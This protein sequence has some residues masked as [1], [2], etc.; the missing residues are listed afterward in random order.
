KDAGQQVVGDHRVEWDAA[1]DV[2][3][4]TDLPLEHDDGA[5]MARG[6]VG[7]GRNQFLDRFVRMF[8]AVEVPEEWRAAEVRKGATN[9]GLEQDDDRE[10]DVR[11]KVTD[12]PVDRLELQP[13][14][15]EI[16]QQQEAAAQGH[17]HRTGAANQQQQ[18]VEQERH[19]RDIER[20][21][22]SDVRTLE[23]RGQPVHESTR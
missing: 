1:L 2:V 9:I 18:L 16:E 7:R 3:A 5:C 20:V 17:L 15:K 8:S 14:R 22:P 23:N 19:D 6:E 21:G 11:R 4:K 10:D 13:L 12:N